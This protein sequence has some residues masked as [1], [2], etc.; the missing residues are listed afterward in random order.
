MTTMTVIDPD[1]DTDGLLMPFRMLLNDSYAKDISKKIK[2]SI[3]AKMKCG[4]FLPAS[5]SV[6]YGYLRDPEN[7]TYAV[8]NEIAEVVR[9]I[10]RLRAAGLGFS[11][12]A[13]KLNDDGVPS[14]GK[15]RYIRDSR[16]TTL[17]RE[18]FSSMYSRR[19]ECGSS[20]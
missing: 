12:I 20:R 18:I 10:F 17:R 4:E 7:K 1:S 16:E 3:S 14:P 11:T 8:D 6:P 9:M 5:G 2:S 13:K 15:L 19:M